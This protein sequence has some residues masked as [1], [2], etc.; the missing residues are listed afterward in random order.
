[1]PKKPKGLSYFQWNFV[2]DVKFRYFPL[3]L[4]SSSSQ[5]EHLKTQLLLYLSSTS[6]NKNEEHKEQWMLQQFSKMAGKIPPFS[7]RADALVKNNLMQM[8]LNNLRD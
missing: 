1:M 7:S 3:G 8:H 4:T 2:E 6:K 5:Y